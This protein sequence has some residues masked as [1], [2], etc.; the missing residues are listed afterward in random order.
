MATCILLSPAVFLP[1]PTFWEESD[2]PEP[3]S[4]F[5]GMKDPGNEVAE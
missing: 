2:Q 1:P 3:G 4:F 5:P